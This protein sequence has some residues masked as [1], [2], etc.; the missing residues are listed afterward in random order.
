M[1]FEQSR[2]GEDARIWTLFSGIPASG[3]LSDFA[4]EMHAKWR[5]TTA[6]ET[7]LLRRDEDRRAAAILGARLEHFDFLDAIYRQGADGVALYADPV[8]ATL[9]EA[10]R[11]LPNMIAIE[12]SRRLEPDDRI[13]C[14]LGI[15]GHVD[16]VL[17]RRA[18]ESLGRPLRY[19][20][21]FPYIMK[22]PDAVAAVTRGLSSSASSVS[23]EGLK[24]W[25]EA[26][27]AYRSQL[28]VVFDESNEEQLIREYTKRTGGVR[29]WAPVPSGDTPGS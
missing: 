7:V 4:Q 3:H 11:G 22:D 29:L 27:K 18:A 8:G 2:R 20:A 13:V 21:D 12:L 16:H 24:A 10:D 1:I 15:G 23:E 19:V 26:V 28:G 14:L 6:R 25:I 5:T 17:V 9:N